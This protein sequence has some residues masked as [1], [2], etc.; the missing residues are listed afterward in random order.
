MV[1]EVYKSV[2]IPVIGMGGIM[3]AEDA[4]QFCIA[5]ARAVAVGTANFV[6]PLAAIEVIEGIERFLDEEGV[7][8]INEIVGSL[9]A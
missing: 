3:C 1:W 4:L 7:A 2:K 5:G 6:N 8:D 9:E